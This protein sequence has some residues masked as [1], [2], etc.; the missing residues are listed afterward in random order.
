MSARGRALAA[1]GA[2]AALLAIAAARSPA[3]RQAPAANRPGRTALVDEVLLSGTK[4][5]GGYF[6]QGGSALRF[7]WSLMDQPLHEDEAYPCLDHMGVTFSTS[8]QRGAS[9]CLCAPQG[10]RGR[11]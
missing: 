8:E 5:G 4:Q 1:S 10:P 7:D 2:L 3:G 6:V 9:T 11:R